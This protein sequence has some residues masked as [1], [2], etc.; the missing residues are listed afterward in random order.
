MAWSSDDLTSTTDPQT[1]TR[2]HPTTSHHQPPSRPISSLTPAPNNPFSAT[3]TAVASVSF[4]PLR[5]RP[6]FQTIF[7]HHNKQQY[8][9]VLPPLT[10]S[11]GHGPLIRN[12]PPVP[13]RQ[14][15]PTTTPRPREA[16]VNPLQR[17]RQR[18]AHP[19]WRHRRQGPRWAISCSSSVSAGPSDPP[20]PQQTIPICHE[21]SC[22][23][24]LWG[25]EGGVL[26]QCWPPGIARAPCSAP[27]EPRR[28][29]PCPLDLGRFPTSSRLPPPGDARLIDRT[30]QSPCANLSDAH[31]LQMTSLPEAPMS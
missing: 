11:S 15:E 27:S 19:R 14:R 21:M 6:R 20:C 29:A 10:P 17:A 18:A 9:Y 13:E 7:N 12:P 1:P 26:G 4:P 23:F 8:P 24:R 3:A 30:T 16:E 5:S 22:G 2:A 28:G 25:R 31:H